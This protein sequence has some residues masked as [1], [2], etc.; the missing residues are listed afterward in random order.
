M[1]KRIYRGMDGS[2]YYYDNERRIET[3]SP[4]WTRNAYYESETAKE[5]AEKKKATKKSQS[6]KDDSI[7]TS[8]KKY[9]RLVIG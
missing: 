3:E 5:V 4:S 1:N 8:D 7:K 9:R 6:V 2:S